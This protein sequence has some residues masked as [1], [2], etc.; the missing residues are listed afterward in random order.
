MSELKSVGPC[1]NLPIEGVVKVCLMINMLCN[2]KDPNQK[3]YIS[4]ENS[5]SETWIIIITTNMSFLFWHSRAL[6][7]QLNTIFLQMPFS[8]LYYD[9]M[10]QTLI[11]SVLIE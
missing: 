11:N 7:S 1:S 8:Y 9:P 3:P 4:V 2:S 10:L 6:F 5:I